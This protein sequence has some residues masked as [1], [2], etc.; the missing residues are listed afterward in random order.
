MVSSECNSRTQG[1]LLPRK[2]DSRKLR[3]RDF[4]LAFAFLRSSDHC[5]VLG[6]A[7]GQARGHEHSLW[8]GRSRNSG[9]LVAFLRNISR[10]QHIR[11]RL[12]NGTAAPTAPTFLASP[13]SRWRPHVAR[14]PRFVRAMLP[15]RTSWI[16]VRPAAE[17][18][19]AGYG[20]SIGVES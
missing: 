2:V 5:G 16:S 19:A 12:R 7:C 11:D 9:L 6:A 15:S 10:S 13:N 3:N 1:V 4:W 17:Q 20:L 8:H 18:V 14:K